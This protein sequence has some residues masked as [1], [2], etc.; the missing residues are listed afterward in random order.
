MN[1]VMMTTRPGVTTATATAT[2]TNGGQSCAV[3]VPAAIYGL[4]AGSAI[5]LTLQN[6]DNATSSTLTLTSIGLPT[7]GTITTSGGYRYHTFGSSGSFVVPA[8]YS[9]SIESILIAGGGAGAGDATSNVGN[10]GGG[11]GGL[12]ALAAATFSAGTYP[13]VVGAGG[14]GA[15]SVTQRSGSNTTFNGS[16]AYSCGGGGFFANNAGAGGGSGGGGGATSGSG[17]AGTAGQGNA[18]AGGNQFVWR[19]W[20][21]SGQFRFWG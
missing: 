15:Y 16:T 3:A 20:R 17:G 12:L 7:G 10:G 4:T 14:A 19:R 6:A 8:G 2:P 9:P 18:G 5:S 21:R 1:P 11:A 13:I